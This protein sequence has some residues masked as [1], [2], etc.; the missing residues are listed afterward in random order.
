MDV[1][2][3]GSNGNDGWWLTGFYGTSFL[4]DKRDYWDSLKHLRENYAL[5]WCICGDFN[6]ILYS[7][8]KIGV[9]RG[10][11]RGLRCFGM[12]CLF[13]IFLTLVL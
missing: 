4:H 1:F 9:H 7:S 11:K 10:R 6:D 13:V 12:C 2:V 8:K 5:T 3:E